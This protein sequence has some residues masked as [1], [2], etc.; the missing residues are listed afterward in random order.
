MILATLLLIDLL[1]CV[2]IVFLLMPSDAR[3]N[4]RWG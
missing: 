3:R 2:G 4:R 1:M